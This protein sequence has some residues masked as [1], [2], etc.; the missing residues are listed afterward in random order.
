MEKSLL[1]SERESGEG[2]RSYFEKDHD[3][4]D[5]LF[6]EFQ[7]LKRIDFVKAKQ[8]FA[9]FKFG[10]QRH[11]IWEEEI[12]FSLFEQKTGISNAGPTFVMRQ[13]HKQ[14]GKILEEIHSKVK[15]ADPASER[16]EEALISILGLHN[17][18][19]ENVL[20]PAIDECLNEMELED[21]FVKM[22]S[23]PEERYQTCCSS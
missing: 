3:R 16:E 6:K 4:L 5:S 2:V 22:N 9:A 20:Y 23:I 17:M 1:S 8:N 13:E 21:V 7:R 18:K 15:A 12:L 14:I 10:L 11:I 19:E